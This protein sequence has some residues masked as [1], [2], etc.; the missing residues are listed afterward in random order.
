[1]SIVFHTSLSEENLKLAKLVLAQFETAKLNDLKVTF[2]SHS[3]S[4]QF[5][6][7]RRVVPVP[8]ELVKNQRWSDIR[9]LFR[10]IL[11]AAPAV[12]N[13]GADN[14]WGPGGEGHL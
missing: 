8:I 1:M 6:Q 9:H 7:D 11:S 2:N 3:Q 13:L 14:E 4:L 5:S 10:A 12:N